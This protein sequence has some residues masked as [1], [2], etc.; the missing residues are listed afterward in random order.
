MKACD[1]Q[2]L[3][4]LLGMKIPGSIKSFIIAFVLPGI[5]RSH[6]PVVSGSPQGKECRQSS[7]VHSYC[8]L[9]E[10]K[11]IEEPDESLGVGKDSQGSTK[12]A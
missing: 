7:F 3:V 8:I 4:F 10:A 11:L 9:D 5:L 2:P 6:C 12:G 1:H